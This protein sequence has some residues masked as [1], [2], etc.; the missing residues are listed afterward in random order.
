M[1]GV[2]LQGRVCRVVTCW[3][4]FGIHTTIAGVCVVIGVEEGQQASPV[5]AI[6]LRTVALKMRGRAFA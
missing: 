2:R 5:R 6:A 4:I 3:T 1:L